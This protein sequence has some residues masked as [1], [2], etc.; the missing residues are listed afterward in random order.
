M[1][2]NPERCTEI[3]RRDIKPTVQ[4]CQE[5][6]EPLTQSELVQEK[7]SG[8]W[9]RLTQAFRSDQVQEIA[10]KLGLVYQSVRKWKMGELPALTTLV[11]I[12]RLTGSSIDWLV[13]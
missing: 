7:D 9:D 5:K 12:R 11:E 8:F 6:N 2:Y 10:D 4:H 3:D 1:M 13:T